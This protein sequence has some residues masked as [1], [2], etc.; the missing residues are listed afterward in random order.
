[1][2]IESEIT[3]I[4]NNVAAAYTAVEEQGGEATGTSS[5]ELA[6]SIKTIPVKA[7]DATLTKSG[8][9]A[10][11]K[12]V[13]DKFAELD[14]KICEIGNDT[15]YWDGNTDGL[16]QSDGAFDTWYKVSDV[17]P[18]LDDLVNGGS[19]YTIC[20]PDPKDSTEVNFTVSDQESFYN[21]VFLLNGNVFIVTEEGAGVLNDIYATT[22]PES[23]IYLFNTNESVY[24]SKFTINGYTGFPTVIESKYISQDLARKSDVFNPVYCTIT[25]DEENAS[26]T[27][28]KYTLAEL[29]NIVS[30]N[31]EVY[32]RYSDSSGKVVICNVEKWDTT[33]STVSF[34]SI[35]GEYIVSIEVSSNSD[36]NDVWTY[37]KKAIQP[38]DLV[39][40]GYISEEGEVT[41]LNVTATEVVTALNNG[42]SVYLYLANEDDVYNLLP[43]SQSS[44]DEEWCEIDFTHITRAAYNN[45]FTFSSNDLLK[46]SAMVT[47]YMECDSTTD[48]I[49]TTVR[50]SNIQFQSL[51]CTV[52]I[53]ETTSMITS[54]SNTYSD[55]LNARVRHAKDT[56]VEYTNSADDIIV[57]KLSY[58][59]DTYETF[60]ATTKDSIITITV[61]TDS[62]GNDVWTYEKT[63]VLTETYII[64]QITAAIGT[65]IGGS[66]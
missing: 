1:M 2:S 12:V 59:G 36:G 56:Y 8:E 58:Y 21:G 50:D 23:G 19:V 45:S 35:V 15:L 30:F 24:I 18:T 4:Q 65:A 9:A 44:F 29:L 16:V 53:D 40:T 47:I 60:V 32:I 66:Y 25:V 39:I 38:K 61:S 31:K 64:N 34:A 28:A 62:D 63:P 46:R 22:F 5:N 49:T 10:D 11:A 43:I 6:E 52:T 54:A 55:L 27:D 57:C 3:R 33:N 48:T 26:I 37:E 13:G 17:V 7:I 42:N 51:I 41:D 20:K 14:E